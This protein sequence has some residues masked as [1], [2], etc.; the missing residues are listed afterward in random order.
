MY[1]TKTFT[2]SLRFMPDFVAVD[3]VDF[4][5]TGG[6]EFPSPLLSQ[7]VIV[8]D[9][10]VEDNSEN[11]EITAEITSRSAGAFPLLTQTAGNMTIQDN[12]GKIKVAFSSSTM[13]SAALMNSSLP[14]VS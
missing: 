11:I 8:D 10:V 4:T 5:F 13:I 3:V 7:I 14:P 1:Y 12:D 9:E 6:S 2:I